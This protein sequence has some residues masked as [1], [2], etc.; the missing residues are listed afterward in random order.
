MGRHAGLTIPLFS[1]ASSR[2]WG[3]G[4]FGDLDALAEWAAGALF[5]RV[6]LLPI[7]EVTGEATSPYSA[8]TAMALDPVY[9][10][11]DALD[12]FAR[13]GGEA[14][15]S[16]A[17]R[18]AL[19][20]ARE[21]GVIRWADVRLAKREALDRACAVFVDEEWTHLTMRASALAAYIARERWWLDDCALYDAIAGSTGARSWLDWPAPLRDRHPAALDLVRRRLAP[22]MLRYQYGQ[23]IAEGQWQEARRAAGERGVAIFGDV[24]FMVA[25]DGPDVW[26]HREQVMLDV[27]LGVPPDAF[28]ADGQ[29]WSLP[30]YRWSAVAE[31][32]F[33]WPRRRMRR[34]AALFD[35]CRVDHL[36]GLYRTYGR[37]ADGGPPFFNP[38]DEPTQLWQGEVLLGIVS[39]A[40]LACLAEDLGV[41]PDFVRA[42]LARLGVPGCKVLRWER[43]WTEPGQP[44]LDPRSYPAV[45]AALTS[46]HDTAT[47]AGWWDEAPLADRAAAC[48]LPGVAEAVQ[49]G[50]ASPPHGWSDAL[51]DAW[52]ALAYASGSNDVFVMIQDIFGWRDRINVPATVGDH[53][54]TWRL[55][56]PV[57]RMGDVGA[58]RERAAW[59]REHARRNGRGRTAV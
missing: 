18:E 19:D 4:E 49:A 59:C 30:T 29:D 22:A 10:A 34:F 8:A 52:L 56:W 38:A 23:W 20:R 36:V 48:A 57:D 25:R 12:D 5:D 54:W 16:R 40:G 43:A 17:A 35:G 21:S 32:G 9:I 53:N 1:A 2:S 58:A 11:I 50:A 46:T 6:M 26:R 15:L 37:P 55:R 13:A 45:S 51:R 24:P 14:A 28:S 41:V 44:F 42:S 47:L 39:S 3:V 33:E 31:A 7:G 27:S